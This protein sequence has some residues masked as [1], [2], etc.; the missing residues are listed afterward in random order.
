MFANAVK[1]LL[2][3]HVQF[4]KEIR[5]VFHIPSAIVPNHLRKSVHFGLDSPHRQGGVGV[6]QCIQRLFSPSPYHDAKGLGL[7]RIRPM[8]ELLILK[9]EDSRT[10]HTS[11]TIWLNQR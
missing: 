10:N 7:Y 3:H 6:A 1:E 8:R 5:A 11:P 4:L 9:P 2:L